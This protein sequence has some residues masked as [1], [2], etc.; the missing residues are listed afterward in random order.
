M[1]PKIFYSG[2][3]DVEFVGEIR[4]NRQLANG[5]KQKKYRILNV[6]YRIM[7]NKGVINK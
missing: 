7:K 2:I 1:E 4:L 3:K 6:E 5:K